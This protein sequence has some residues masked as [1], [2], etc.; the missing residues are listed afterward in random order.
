MPFISKKEKRSIRRR[1]RG[2]VRDHI[3]ERITFVSRDKCVPN[4]TTF[5]KELKQEPGWKWM[6]LSKGDKRRN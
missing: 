2:N 4:D 5:L 1:A 6:D 3:K